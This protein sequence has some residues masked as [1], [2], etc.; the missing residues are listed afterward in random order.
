MSD[1][2]AN[3]AKR[4]TFEA[5]REQLAARGYGPTGGS[6]AARRVPDS[7][8]RRIVRKKRA[9]GPT[10]TPGSQPPPSAVHYGR[11]L[12]RRST[13]LSEAPAPG[14]PVVLHEA[15]EG[16]E[17][18]CAQQG[19][20]YLV[21]RAVADID[22]A[23]RELDT[24]FSAC[25]AD[26]ASPLSRRLARRCDVEG[27]EPSDV[28]FMDVESTGLGNSPLFLIGIM[29]WDESG[30]TTYQYLARNYA[31]ES[32]AIRFFVEACAS[33]R[34]LVTFNGKSFDFPYIRARAA[35]NGIRFDLSP[36]HFDLLHECRRIWRTKLP[37][38]RLQTL[39]RHICG[40]TRHGDIPGSE[41]PDAYH[42]FVR[43]E[44]AWQIVPILK[45][46]MLDLVTLADLMTRMPVLEND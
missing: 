17:V 44:N 34:L 29:L 8:I 4:R 40:R 2:T 25:L 3:N 28:I 43:T 12:P 32:A 7:E 33:R 46:N 35:A 10:P 45:H 19:T 26:T 9:A 42:A 22:D 11:D 16:V 6:G 30:F 38:C 41:I 36:I 31:E 15:V 13:P 24:G 21:T 14:P 27:L 5:L 18:R 1:E 39:E 20:V 23:S 37:D